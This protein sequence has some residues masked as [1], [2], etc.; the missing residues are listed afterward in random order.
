[1]SFCVCVFFKQ[2]YRV[3]CGGG[4]KSAFGI[5][6]KVKFLALP[7]SSYIMQKLP[8]LLSLGFVSS[9]IRATIS[10]R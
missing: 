4:Q 5:K 7:S 2:H 8:N 10:S 6:T 1:M 9:K 3:L